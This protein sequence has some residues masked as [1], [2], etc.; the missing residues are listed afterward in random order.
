M[1]ANKPAD[2][3][4]SASQWTSTALSGWCSMDLHGWADAERRI[5]HGYCRL[6]S[7]KCGC[8][9]HR[10]ERVSRRQAWSPAQDI[11]DPDEKDQP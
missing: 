11:I 6:N 10:G 9:C 5:E 2:T 1:A 4:H 7:T 8:C 3:G